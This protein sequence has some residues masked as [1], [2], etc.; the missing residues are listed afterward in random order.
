M[1]RVITFGSIFGALAATLFL[2]TEIA[3]VALAA[4]WSLSGLLGLGTGA[5]VLLAIVIGMPSLYG[6]LRAAILAFDAETDPVN[7]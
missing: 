2:L 1:N 3:A 5:A 7:N 6:A 4:V